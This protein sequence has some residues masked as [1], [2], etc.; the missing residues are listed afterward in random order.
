[1]KNE[2]EYGIFKNMVSS[3]VVVAKHN[4][5]HSKKGIYFVMGWDIEVTDEC[6]AWLESLNETDFDAVDYSVDLL[7]DRGPR[8]SHPHSS[9]IN[10]SRHA[11]MRELRVQADGKPLRLFYA[12]DPRR[13]VIILLGG[14]KTGDTRFYDRMIPVAD[15]LYDVHLAELR[16]E[17][18]IP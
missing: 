1:M 12:F 13:T 7:I 14:D 6:H 5:R 2:H 11:H 18:W 9:K 16:Q 4:L 10:G 3:E 15:V 17:G 8:L